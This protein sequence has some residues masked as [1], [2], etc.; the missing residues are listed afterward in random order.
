MNPVSFLVFCL[1]ILLKGLTGQQPD[2]IGYLCF[3]SGWGRLHLSESSR[4]GLKF[5]VKRLEA[6]IEA[7]VLAAAVR[8]LL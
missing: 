4:S 7:A 2:E 6:R 3:V 5:R 1:S 8:S